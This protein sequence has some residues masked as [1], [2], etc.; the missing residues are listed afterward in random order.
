MLFLRS[1]IPHPVA[2]S[3]GPFDVHWYGLL[4]GCA[5]LLGYVIVSRLSPRFM[6]EKTRATDIYVSLFVGGLVG[7]RLYHVLLQL[8]LY[9]ARP[10]SILEIWNGGLAIHGG[11]IGGG[12]VLWYYAR[13]YR[14]SFWSFADL[15]AIPL[16]IGQAIGRW[17]NYFN[18]ELFGRPTDLPW[19]IAIQQQ[20]R[21]AAHAASPYF[22][23]AFLYES[24][25]N[26]IGAGLLLLLL[27][28]VKKRPRG[29][30][31]WSYA[32]W[33][34]LGRAMMEFVRIDTPPLL[35]GVRIPLVVSVVLLVAS[36]AMIVRLFTAPVREP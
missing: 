1:Y 8:P 26:V 28:C 21:P 18:Q 11:V 3:I 12:L 6:I 32:A 9:L 20:Y 36:C 27:L 31:V 35:F 23:P 4:L 19:G 13:R 14:M 2:F 15:Y 17:G 24:A 33:Y 22:H 5:A 34:S 29:L 7:A 10:F 25:W 16:M 30:L